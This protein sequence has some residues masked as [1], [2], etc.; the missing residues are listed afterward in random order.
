MLIVIGG[1]VF[2]YFQRGGPMMWPLLVCSLVGLIFII[3][4]I[5]AYRRI[6]GD[7]AEIFSGIRESL[8]E[9][10]LRGSL[11]VCESF[12][13]PVA[14]TLKSGLLRFGKSNDEI[15]KAMESVALHEI[16]KLEKGLWVLAT[17]ANTAPLFGFLGTVTGMISSFEALAEVGLGNPQAVASGIAEAL[18]T[19]ATG[20]TI[21][22]PVQ[23]AYNYFNNRVS[24]FAL[25][26][27]T[28]SSMLLET[29]SE[30]EEKG[31]TVARAKSV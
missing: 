16:S 26:M 18:I 22:L 19:T 8:L 20:L 31:P 11:E 17:V 12:D 25:D 4:R 5:I 23:A 1:N 15:E 30:I 6:Q 14:T 9:R 27:E 29:F 3:E 28:S 21:A 24:N 13:H 2:N 7:T 10:N